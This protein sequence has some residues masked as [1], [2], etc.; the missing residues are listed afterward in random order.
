MYYY[1]KSGVTFSVYCTI[2]KLLTLMFKGSLKRNLMKSKA[3]L[4]PYSSV[5]EYNANILTFINGKQH[6]RIHK[7]HKHVIYS[8]HPKG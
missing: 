7:R 3:I 8:D 2:D 5:F 4:M 1:T 6:S